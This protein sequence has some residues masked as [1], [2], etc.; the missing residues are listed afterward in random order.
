[1][2]LVDIDTNSIFYQGHQTFEPLIAMS[3]PSDE[4]MQEYMKVNPSYSK[5]YSFP[6]KMD[7]RKEAEQVNKRNQEK[8]KIIEDMEHT[9]KSHV[10][11]IPSFEM[12][13]QIH[14]TLSMLIRYVRSF[15]VDGRDLA[16]AVE[17]LRNGKYHEVLRRAL[18]ERHPMKSELVEKIVNSQYYADYL[19]LWAEE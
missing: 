14:N 17:E 19:N 8:N 3:R 16:E 12:T 6:K 4:L 9:I 18:L 2:I 15:A 11:K 1:M 13:P 10:T 7:Q 5:S